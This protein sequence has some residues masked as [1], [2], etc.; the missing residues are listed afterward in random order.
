MQNTINPGQLR[1]WWTNDKLFL[2]VETL[3]M[4]PTDVWKR[5]RILQEGKMAVVTEAE[6]TEKSI[7][8]EN[9]K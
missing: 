2:V 7:L 3:S 8:V 9:T 5:Y 4:M 6:I 1:V